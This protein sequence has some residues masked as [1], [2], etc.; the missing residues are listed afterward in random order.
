MSRY[1]YNCARELSCLSIVYTLC[2]HFSLTD[3][4][5]FHDA[6]VGNSEEFSLV[7]YDETMEEGHE[8]MKTATLNRG[9]L[10]KVK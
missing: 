6:G 10:K 5:I 3:T 8:E 9:T 4:E 2:V 1:T 7:L